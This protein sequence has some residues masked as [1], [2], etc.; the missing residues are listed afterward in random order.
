MENLQLVFHFLKLVVPSLCLR[1]PQTF[2]PVF[3]QNNWW[4]PVSKLS[5]PMA[6]ETLCSILALKFNKDQPFRFE[7]QQCLMLSSDKKEF[8][9]QR[10]QDYEQAVKVYVTAQRIHNGEELGFRLTTKPKFIQVSFHN[11]FQERS[12]TMS[13][14]PRT[15]TVPRCLAPILGSSF[16]SAGDREPAAPL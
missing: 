8:P 6:S 11:L 16:T 2:Q 12:R 3:V 7:G 4:D 5:L 14:S 1:T 13:S 9:R 15:P 10:D